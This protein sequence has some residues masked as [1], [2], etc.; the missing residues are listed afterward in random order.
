MKMKK[1]DLFDEVNKISKIILP[2]S[3]PNLQSKNINH[4][5]A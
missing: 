2:K 1:K 5:E 4:S 3:T